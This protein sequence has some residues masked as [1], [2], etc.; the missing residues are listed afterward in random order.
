MNAA[1]FK[2]TTLVNVEVTSSM[3]LSSRRSAGV[4]ADVEIRD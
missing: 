2:S 3:Q 4:D 1:K